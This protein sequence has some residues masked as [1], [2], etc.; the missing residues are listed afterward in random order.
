MVLASV[1]YPPAI[2]RWIPIVESVAAAVVISATNPL[3]EALLPYLLAPGFAAGVTVGLRGAVLAS[4]LAAMVL[5]GSPV[6]A[7]RVKP[8][9]TT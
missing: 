8:Q 2:A 3:D 5:L 6:A 9:T 1:P 7:I 4:G